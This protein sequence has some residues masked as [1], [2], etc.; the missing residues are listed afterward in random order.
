MP[1]IT[2]HRKIRVRFYKALFHAVHIVWPVFSGLFLSIIALG[3]LVGYL[4]AWKPI[5]GIY[6]AFI[7]ALTVGYGD[8]VPTQTASRFIAIWIGFTGILITALFA[9]VSV[10][11]LSYAIEENQSEKL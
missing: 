10:R 5:E 11:A 9:A 4:E 2:D 8:F 1:L 6:F 7:T 3:L